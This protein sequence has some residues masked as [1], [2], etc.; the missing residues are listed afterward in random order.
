MLILS[1]CSHSSNKEDSELGVLAKWWTENTIPNSLDDLD[2]SD[3]FVVKNVQDRGEY[4]ERPK[5]ATGVIVSS[6]KKLAA[7]AAWRNKEHKGPWQIYGEQETNTTAFHYVG[8]SDIVFI[9]WV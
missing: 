6:Q 4:Y 3:A 9:G 8:D 5:D 7:M 2:L 1:E